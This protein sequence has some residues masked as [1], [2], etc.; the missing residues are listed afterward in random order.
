V[1]FGQADSTGTLASI[2]PSFSQKGL[3]PFPTSV[4]WIAAL[5]D[6]KN[7]QNQLN[8]DGIFTSNNTNIENE[9]REMEKNLEDIHYFNWAAQMSDIKGRTTGHKDA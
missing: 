4:V 5:I 2:F 6:A 7:V 3:H 9:L 1:N 8:H